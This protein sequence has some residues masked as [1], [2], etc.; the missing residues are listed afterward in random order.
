MSHTLY[1]KLLAHKEQHKKSMAVLIDPD[2]IRLDRFS[3]VLEQV[4]RCQVDFLF[5]GGS[6]VMNDKMDEVLDIIGEKTDIPR[7]L[8]PG[9]V[10]QVNPKADAILLLSLISGRNPELLIGQHVIAAPYLKKSGLEIIP[11]GYLLIDGNSIS[12]VQYISNTTPIPANKGDI[13]ASTA[14]A[15]EM[16]G[17]KCLFLDAGSGAKNPIPAP[18]INQVS[19]AVESPLIV[20]GGIRSREDFRNALE[21]GADLLVI[22]DIIE[23]D[24]SMV[25][26][27]SKI[28]QTFNQKTKA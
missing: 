20:G 24:P 5:I 15:G 7:I 21:A 6:L 16:L 18:L 2:Q 9:N 26:A 22:G 10:F 19:Q 1:Q 8:F 23:K 25:E 3:E 17:L 4:N 14:M 27:F 13:A 12:S 28:L 11:T